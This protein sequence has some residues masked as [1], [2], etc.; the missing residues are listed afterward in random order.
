[1]N[2][3][4]QAWRARLGKELRRLR[5]EAGLRGDEA[6]TR[7]E[8]AKSTISRIENGL[9]AKIRLRDLNLL[10]DLYGVKEAGP[11]ATI[12]A[13][14][15]QVRNKKPVQYLDYLGTAFALYL[16]VEEIASSLRMYSP[17][18]V[19][20]LLQTEE[21]MR[22][23]LQASRPAHPSHVLEQLVRVRLER[24][25]ILRRVDPPELWFVIDEAV[26]RRTVGGKR[27]MQ[28]QLAHL[29]DSSE[30]S[31][32]T[33]QV[34]ALSRGAHVGNSGHFTVAGIRPGSTGDVVQSEG[35][36][37]T[38]YTDYPETVRSCSVAF[39]HLRATALSEDASRELMEKV[40]ADLM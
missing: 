25:K 22:V 19:P 13:I 10:L 6:A 33:V 35:M 26:L 5:E 32:I 29:I 7:M 16:V 37:G 1:M 4:N 18:A 31:H 2:D 15:Q 3:D 38:I 14:A 11:R 27:V 24:Q 23:Q 20:G 36:A 17:L 28:A 40:A 12:H 8:W 30:T 9:T 34:L 21:Y 39:D